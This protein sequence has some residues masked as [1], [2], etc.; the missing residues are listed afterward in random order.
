MKKIILIFL[1]LFGVFLNIQS[2]NA[3]GL[4][5]QG[6]KATTTTRTTTT[7]SNETINE[8]DNTIEED[9]VSINVF[10]STLPYLIVISIGLFLILLVLAKITK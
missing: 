9:K 7:I 2:V 10:A 8:D 4:I 3:E 6:T 1:L 5:Y